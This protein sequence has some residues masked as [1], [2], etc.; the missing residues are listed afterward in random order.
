M[1]KRF[2][3]VYRSV[4]TEFRLT[5]YP[6]CRLWCIQSAMTDINNPH[7]LSKKYL[8]NKLTYTTQVFNGDMSRTLL[9][10]HEYHP[11]NASTITAQQS[12][13]TGT[14][15]RCSFSSP[16][17]QPREELLNEKTETELYN[18][19]LCNTIWRLAN[20][21]K[22]STAVPLTAPGATSHIS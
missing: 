12:W 22:L 17:A 5:Q 15:I 4:F 2:S 21:G 6:N 8:Q 11:Q 1:E 13:M 9:T 18:D 7:S 19:V 3:I 10:H 14:R 20:G 16:T